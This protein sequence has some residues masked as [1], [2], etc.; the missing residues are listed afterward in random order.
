MPTGYAT[1]RLLGL[2]PPPGGIRAS[3][4]IRLTSGKAEMKSSLAKQF[5]YEHFVQLIL[6]LLM[7]SDPKELHLDCR[8][9]ADTM[10]F[11]SDAASTWMHRMKDAGLIKGS[12][13]LDGTAVIELTPS[14]HQLGVELLT[15]RPSYGTQFVQ[16]LA[17]PANAVD[18]VKAGAGAL[19]GAAATYLGLT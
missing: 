8:K 5:K 16:E 15:P 9:L 13:F 10:P 14:G 2:R 19:L 7:V 18:F 6:S 17:K 4:L 3:V 11:D 12:F 1:P